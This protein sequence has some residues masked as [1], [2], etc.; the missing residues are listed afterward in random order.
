MNLSTE[1]NS[2]APDAESLAS[3]RQ[4]QVAGLC[5]LVA[6]C[7]GFDTQAI[8]FVAPVISKQWGVAPNQFGPGIMERLK[9]LQAPVMFLWAGKDHF[10]PPEAVQAINAELRAANKS[11]VSA[12]FSDADHGF[13]CDQRGSY[14]A[15]TAA[16]AWPMTLAYLAEKT[17]KAA[18]A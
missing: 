5:A 9:N 15:A 16:V 11:F 1:P 6:V 4:W 14:Q 8:A 13:F 12:E 7:D 10:I 2:G 3:A 17:Q 18:S